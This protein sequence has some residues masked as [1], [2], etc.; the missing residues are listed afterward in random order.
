MNTIQKLLAGFMLAVLVIGYGCKDDDDD[1]VGCNW[2][3][4]VQDEAN[5]L[6]DAATAYANDPNNSVLC[7]NYKDAFND[8][9]DA[10]EDHKECAALSG[11]QD[12]LQDAIDQSRDSLNAL[13]C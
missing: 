4:E 5:A 11:Q 9:L 6:T 8:Y 2:A 10:L 1:P 12:E 13:Q 3:S 7:Q